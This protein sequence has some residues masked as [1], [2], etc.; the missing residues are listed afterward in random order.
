MPGRVIKQVN[1]IG[2]R[3]KHGRKFQFLNRL[4]EPYKWT[5]VIPKDNPKFQGILEEEEAPFPDIPA[6][7]SGVS[8]EEDKLDY[9]VVTDKPEPDFNDLATVALENADIN[10]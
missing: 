1:L 4:R 5:N 2:S 10:T 3:E 8:L 6:K 7:L 9:Q